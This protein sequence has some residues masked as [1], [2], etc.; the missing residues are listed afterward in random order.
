MKRP[1]VEFVG[2]KAEG[3]DVQFRLRVPLSAQTVNIDHLCSEN[4]L[5]PEKLAMQ[6]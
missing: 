1:T 6:G 2:A 3:D 4:L 5:D